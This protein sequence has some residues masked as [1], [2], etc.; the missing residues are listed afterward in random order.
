[1]EGLGDGHGFLAGHGV[2]HEERLD[3][4]DRGGDRGDLGHERRVDRQATG[5]VDDDDVTDLAAGGGDAAL[6]DVDDARPVRRPE[7]RDVE[8][9]AQGLELVRGVGSVRVGGDEDRPTAELH[10]VPGE[11]GRGRRLARALQAGDEDHGRV[12][13]QVED[14]VAGRQE[15]HELLVDDPHDLLAGRQAGQDV[16]PDGPL[17]DARDEV[18]DDLEVDVGLEQAEPDLAHR[19][20]HVGLADPAPAGQ[21]AEGLAQALAE[22]VEHPVGLAPFSARRGGA[23]AVPVAR[24]F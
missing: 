11:L 17:A 24:E 8:A 6:G 9:L 2:D 18:L 19:D 20:V 4:I 16:G 23:L 7:D 10:D 1:M 5:G 12:A 21:V 14:P 13:L 22:R 15:R 3:R